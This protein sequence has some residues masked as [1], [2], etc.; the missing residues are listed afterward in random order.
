MEP[1][2][3]PVTTRAAQ[4]EGDAIAIMEL[5]WRWHYFG[6]LCPGRCLRPRRLHRYAPDPPERLDHDC[7]LRPELGLVTEVFEGAATTAVIVWAGR[8]PAVLGLPEQTH[9]LTPRP[10]TLDLEDPDLDLFARC[11]TVHEDDAPIR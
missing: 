2:E 10:A 4:S 8:H 6:R 3:H 7:S 11:G 1:G 5:E 9:H